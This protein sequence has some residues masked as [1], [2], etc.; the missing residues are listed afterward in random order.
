MKFTTS[1]QKGDKDS[2]YLPRIR[3]S[4]NNEDTP[5][6][7]LPTIINDAPFLAGA[8]GGWKY[9]GSPH[10]DKV[11]NDRVSRLYES[12]GRDLG[13]TIDNSLD[14]LRDIE[15][16]K[17]RHPKNFIINGIY[18][19]LLRKNNEAMGM[20]DT[21]AFKKET[22]SFL[23]RLGNIRQFFRDNKAQKDATLVAAKALVKAK[24][25]RVLDSMKNTPKSPTSNFGKRSAITLGSGIIAQL[26][27]NRYLK[28]DL[29]DGYNKLFK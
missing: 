3:F 29:T 24:S 7:Q 9:S 1:I 13:Q 18:N 15:K 21:S 25:A 26:L 6:K 8:Y 16:K 17:N 12:A 28:Q 14:L 27:Y 20:P 5:Y 22:K 11:L 19:W 10:L 23:G 4:K 2:Y